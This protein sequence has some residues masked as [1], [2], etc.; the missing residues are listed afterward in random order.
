[1]IK[2][3]LRCYNGH[4][5]DSWFLDSDSYAK[6]QTMKLVACPHCG[7]CEVAKAI[8]APNVIRSAK[9]EHSQPMLHPEQQAKLMLREWTSFVKSNFEDVGKRFS[10]E[11]RLIHNGESEARSIFG[12]ATLGEALQLHEEGIEINLLPELP[13]D[14]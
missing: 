13:T 11:V 7:I 9:G 3:L 12:Q 2:F 8:T 6:Q 5:F 10:D 1:M 4:E 14:S